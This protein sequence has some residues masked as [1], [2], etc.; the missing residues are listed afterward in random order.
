MSPLG[1]APVISRSQ[2]SAHSRMT[3]SAYLIKSATDR[4]NFRLLQGLLPVLAFSRESK[5]VLGLSVRDLVDTE[6]FVRCAKKAGKVTLDILNVVQLRGKRIVD[7]NDND[8]PVGLFLVQ[9]GHDTENLDL[10]DLTGVT[11]K[12]TDFAH[13]QWVVVTL[14]LGLG[15]DNIGIFPGLSTSLVMMQVSIKRRHVWTHA[16]EGTVVPEVAFVGEAVADKTQ[17]ALL[18]ILFDG[19]EELFLGDL[20]RRSRIQLVNWPPAAP[21]LCIPLAW[22]WSN[23]ESQQSCSKQSSA[24]WRTEEYRGRERRARHPSRCTHGARECGRRRVCG[25]NKTWRGRSNSRTVRA[26]KSQ[27]ALLTEQHD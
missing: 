8:L 18:G 9:E 23:E 2:A 4:S 5:L 11:N 22:R 27:Y 12:L 20:Q 17:L 1:V 19:V 26:R 7:I 14:G 25:W 10:L 15:V 16:R 13:V 21:N 6:P 24:R 3:S